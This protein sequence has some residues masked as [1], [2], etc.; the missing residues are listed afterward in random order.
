MCVPY[1]R[2]AHFG[3]SLPFLGQKNNHHVFLRMKPRN[4]ISLMSEVSWDPIWVPENPARGFLK[5]TWG[6]NWVKRQLH[7]SGSILSRMSRQHMSCSL[8]KFILVHK[9]P[10]FR[11]CVFGSPNW[12]REGGTCVCSCWQHFILAFW[13]HCGPEQPPANA[14]E[15]CWDPF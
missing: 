2:Q 4:T 7:L 9:K 8:F 15:V 6:S 10:I 13:G 11:F 1:R 3:L 5:H 14:L 12:H